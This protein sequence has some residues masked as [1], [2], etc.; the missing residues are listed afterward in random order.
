MAQRGARPGGS[1]CPC[2]MDSWSSSG[3]SGVGV[4]AAKAQGLPQGVAG[5]LAARTG[6]HVPLHLRA[7]H[8]VDLA[9]EVPGEQVDDVGTARGRSGL[10]QSR[11]RQQRRETVAHGDAGSVQAALDRRDA[12][13]SDLG[14]LGRREALDVAQQQHLAVRR[15]QR[16]DG[17]LEGRRR[18]PDPRGPARDR[19]PGHGLL[20]PA[21]PPIPATGLPERRHCD[22]ALLMQKLRAMV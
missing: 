12:D 18:P 20:A 13:A 14:D 5:R 4:G 10:G 7:G 15:L 9:L 2:R 8:G 3:T 21:A 16:G 17:G 22:A 6:R 1:G 19:A 11:R